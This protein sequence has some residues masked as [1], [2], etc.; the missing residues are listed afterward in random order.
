[1]MYP[2]EKSLFIIPSHMA[3]GQEGSS[4]GIVPAFTPVIFEVEIIEV[5][6]RN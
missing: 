1:M 3:F 5:R 6:P 4:T 2:G